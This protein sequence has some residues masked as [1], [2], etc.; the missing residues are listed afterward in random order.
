MSDLDFMGTVDELLLP[1][2]GKQ[3]PFVEEYLIDFNGTRAAIAA[4]YSEKTATSMASENLRKPH[5][6]AAITAKL[7]ESAI[8]NEVTIDSLTKDLRSAVRIGKQEGQAS[9]VT[10]AVMAMAKI[11]GFAN[12]KSTIIHKG[13]VNLHHTI[14]FVTPSGP[15]TNTE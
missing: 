4:G 9:G 14:E 10:G 5:I 12:D 1:M 6:I 15:P 3:A 13:D 7:E 2:V 8:R 11:H